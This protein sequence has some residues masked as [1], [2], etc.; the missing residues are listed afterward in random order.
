MTARMDAWPESPEPDHLKQ[1]R[2]RLVQST[3]RPAGHVPGRDAEDVV[4]EAMIRF[5]AEVPRPGVP[6]D[7]TRAHVALKRERANYF[8]RSAHKPEQLSAEP[9]ALRPGGS[10]PDA[11][12]V[13]AAVAIE[14]IAGRDARLVAEMRGAG[15]TF[16][17]VAQELEWSAQRVEAARKQLLRNKERIATAVS[18]QLK[19]ASDDC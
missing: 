14:Q 7:V 9:T 11:R 18:I 3:R 4:Q 13:Q 8:R 10:G 19:E 17:D 5:L 15:H 6:G 16:D 2:S 12:L 1:L